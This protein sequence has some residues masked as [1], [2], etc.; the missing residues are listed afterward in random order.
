ML[1][2]LYLFYLQDCPKIS[3]ENFEDEKY[4]LMKHINNTD[5]YLKN[6][7]LSRIF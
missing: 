4:F 7:I 3:E 5:R 6:C 1:D 2:W